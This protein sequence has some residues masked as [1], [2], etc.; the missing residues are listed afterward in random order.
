MLGEI[1]DGF[2]V[3]MSALDNGRYSVAAGCVGICDGCVDA[4][5]A[6]AKERKQFGVPLARFQ[7][8]QEMIADMILKRDASRMLV[9]RAGD[10]QGRRQ[11][12]HDRD[13]GGEA[14]RDRV[15]GRVREPGD[16]GP[17]RRR[18]R[19]RL[20]GR[21][22]P[23]RRPRHHPLRGHLADPEADHRP[24][25]DRDQRDDA[26]RGRVSRGRPGRDLGRR[27]HVALLRLNRPEAR[28][29]LSPEMMEEIAAE[30]E[31]LDADPEVRCIVIA[32]SDE[33]FAAGADIKAMSERS[34]AEALH[35]PAA[36][37]LA[38]GWPRSRRR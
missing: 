16:P 35:H 2:K 13:L 34:F 14:L 4:S 15:G 11:A 29:A 24:R 20:P 36:A 12:E 19:R 1:G 32:G 8:V 33:V 25:R 6:Y 17:R 28:N 7:L 5:V 22:L 3:A 26:D 31:R 38:A 9:Y 21:A 10:A 30:L 27:V 18:L 37:L 23:A